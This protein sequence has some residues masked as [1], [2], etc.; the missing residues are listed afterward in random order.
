MR[1]TTNFLNTNNNANGNDFCNFD[2]FSNGNRFKWTSPTDLAAM[3]ESSCSYQTALD[4]KRIS[5]P[6]AATAHH[7]VKTEDCLGL[8]GQ[9]SPPDW[10]SY[11]FHQSTFEQLK[12]SV[13]KAK[14]AL[15]D[16]TTFFGTSSAFS[17]IYGAPR[18][19]DT[20]ESVTNLNSSSGNGSGGGSGGGGGGG[21][22]NSGHSGSSN[23]NINSSS[24][25]SS[26]L[27]IN[28]NCITTISGGTTLQRY[29]VDTLPT[30]Q[31][32]SNNSLSS[33]SAVAAALTT[34]LDNVIENKGRISDKSSSLCLT[35]YG[36]SDS[37]RTTSKCTSESS[38]YT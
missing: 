5:P 15:Q 3:Y 25:V 22:G 6:N 35:S 11:R 2:V 20:L 7:I 19:T 36:L 38:C 10:S 13:E 21:G 8:V 9:C 4:L 16:R 14:A 37:L 31:V 17:D 33:S 34:S 26:S 30:S 18:L 23:G 12:Q 29:R 28:G 24:G 1:K 32:S 27:S